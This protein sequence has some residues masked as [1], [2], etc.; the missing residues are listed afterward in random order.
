MLS[1]LKLLFW[2][3]ELNVCRT[4]LRPMIVALA[5]ASDDGRSGVDSEHLEN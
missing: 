5:A 1:I 4:A 2:V 3:R